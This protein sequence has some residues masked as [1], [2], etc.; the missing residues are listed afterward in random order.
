HP[1]AEARTL[2]QA[3]YEIV[4][5]VAPSLIRYTEATPY[6]RNFHL[7]PQEETDPTPSTGENVKLIWSTPEA[8]ERLIASLLFRQNGRDYGECLRLAFKLPK[9]KKEEVV[10]NALRYLKP[11]DQVRREF[12][13]IDLVYEL[14]VSASCFAQLKRH[15][16]ATIL[17]QEYH[18]S[19]GVTVP[20][21]L[22]AAGLEDV[23]SEMIKET[24]EVFFRV[25]REV[26][27]AA[28]YI[29]TNGHRRRVLLKINARELYHIARLRA[30]KHAQWDIRRLTEE[31]I[32]TAKA[33]MP[34][35]LMLACGRDAFPE[36][37]NSIFSEEEF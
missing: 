24:E 26:P 15:R 2:A 35:T 11:Y 12:E 10:K 30:D 31:M 16:M 28:P 19:L 33:V 5:P 3:L 9:E 34:I 20:P 14:V 21:N 8:D 13:M 22:R 25:R 7:I 37:Y 6:D 18:P 1:L 29:L 23:F 32:A 36:L 4:H 27:S 17:T